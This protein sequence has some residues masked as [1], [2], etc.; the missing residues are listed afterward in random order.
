ML[1]VLLVMFAMPAMALITPDA[2]TTDKLTTLALTTGWTNGTD[3]TGV[4]LLTFTT[5]NGTAL[6]APLAGMFYSSQVATGLTATALTT[7]A[8][9]SKGQIT[10]VVAAGTSFYHFITN[11]TGELDLTITAAA[12]TWY[13]VF[14]Q[15]DHKLL[16]T[17]AL[18]ITGP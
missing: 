3:G 2:V 8:T 1:I 11:A 10:P 5:P 15:P 4:A 14:T 12:G 9:A 17:G 6:T 7:G 13:I 16:L 18:A